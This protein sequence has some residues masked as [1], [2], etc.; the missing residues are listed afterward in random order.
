MTVSTGNSFQQGVAKRSI[1]RSRTFQNQTFLSCQL[2]TTCATNFFAAFGNHVGV[3][4]SLGYLVSH[5]KKTWPST[6]FKNNCIEF[7]IETPDWISYV[8]LMLFFLA[9]QIY[10]TKNRVF[11]KHKIGEI[12]GESLKAAADDE[13]EEGTPVTSLLM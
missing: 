10:L 4:C 12:K 3:A 8:S 11:I 1:R 2:E 9:L 13:V 5:E 7:E 6:S